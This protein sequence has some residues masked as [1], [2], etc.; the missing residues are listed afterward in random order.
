MLKAPKFLK[1]K[2]KNKKKKKKKKKHT[3]THTHKNTFLSKKSLI[4]QYIE[5][6]R[7][8]NVASACKISA[9]LVF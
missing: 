9:S 5:L 3:H 1:K 6:I 7:S 4:N 2:K 8:Y